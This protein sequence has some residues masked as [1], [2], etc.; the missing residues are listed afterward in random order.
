[1]KVVKVSIPN[2]GAQIP[3]LPHETVGPGVGGVGGVGGSRVTSPV[4]A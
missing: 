3:A 4:C 1:L 2:T